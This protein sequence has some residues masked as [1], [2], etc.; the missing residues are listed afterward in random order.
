MRTTVVTDKGACLGYGGKTN[1]YNTFRGRLINRY[2]KV[3]KA[4][5][6]PICL[7]W[8]LVITDIN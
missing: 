5:E 3:W 4:Y 6:E 8:L 2:I 1:T 7:I